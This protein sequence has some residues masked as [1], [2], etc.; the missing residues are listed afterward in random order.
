MEYEQRVDRSGSAGPAVAELTGL[1]GPFVFP[2]K[3]LQ[4]IWLHREFDLARAVTN[5]GR[6]VGVRSPGRWNL[7]GGPDFRDAR[8][9]L[10]GTPL[11]GDVEVH[12][13]AT[14]WRAHGH[15]HDPAYRSVVLHVVLFPSSELTTAGWEDAPI[16]I[17]TVLPLLLHDLEEYAADAAVAALANRP[18]V[19][20]V[21]WLG[22]LP[23]ERRL[24]RLRGCAL[25]R[26]RQK[27]RFARLRLDRLGWREACH[28]SALEI[29]GY[30]FNRVPMIRIA[31]AF[32]LLVWAGRGIEPDALVAAEQEH[33]ALQGVRPANQPRARLR[34]YARWCATVPDWPER[35]Y[36]WGRSMAMERP[37]NDDA[38][39]S[40]FRRA[41]HLP[42]LRSALAETIV[43]GAVTGSRLDT[44]VCD[45]FLP[46][47]AAA[48]VAAD[49][50]HSL[51]WHWY[52]G[53]VPDYLRRGL[54]DLALA[55]DARAP[56][57]HGLTQGLIGGLLARETVR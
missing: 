3:L 57:C 5:D 54:R 51:W 40:R 52:E 49:V 13:R 42:Q 33:W 44:L 23:T 4:Q 18:S 15:Q 38:D 25:A 35:L 43:G 41:A 19:Q 28:Q 27:V 10:G 2:E 7:L 22:A 17:L 31:A 16:P 1:E 45:G 56:A 34:Q 47:L 36:V 32:P 37:G 48:D 14:D 29:L 21:E 9:E 20:I 24:E 53:D 6:R 26:W 55:G 12:V 30:R 46:L 11:L 50:G 8:L 39:T